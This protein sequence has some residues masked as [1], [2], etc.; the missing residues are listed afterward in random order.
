MDAKESRSNRCEKMH[1]Q[2][3]RFFHRKEGRHSEDRLRRMDASTFL[4][5][6]VMSAGERATCTR[7]PLQ[8]WTTRNF[9]RLPKKRLLP[10]LLASL[11]LE[12]TCQARVLLLLR[13]AAFVIVEGRAVP[14]VCHTRGELGGGYVHRVLA[15]DRGQVLPCRAVGGLGCTVAHTKRT[16][17][18][19]A[20][21]S[22]N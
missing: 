18:T 3:S 4:S 19:T 6:C 13:G 20:L 22:N 8:R 11:A 7:P 2:C 17:Q 10:L 21:P 9:G 1:A 16:E 14:F 5:E 15:E 12:R